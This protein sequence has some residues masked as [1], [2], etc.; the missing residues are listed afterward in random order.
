MEAQGLPDSC[1]TGLQEA[2]ASRKLKRSRQAW[3]GPLTFLSSKWHRSRRAGGWRL[4]PGPCRLVPW[5][6]FQ[7]PILCPGLRDTAPGER[8]ADSSVQPAR[9]SGSPP[10]E[11][12]SRGT[13]AAARLAPGPRPGP[14]GHT[15]GQTRLFLSGSRVQIPCTLQDRGTRRPS[16]SHRK[17]GEFWPAA[18][19]VME[20]DAETLPGSSSALLSHTG[21]FE[22]RR[23]VA[24]GRAR[25]FS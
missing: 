4:F 1:Q 14:A 15:L 10:S 22:T 6:G 25:T 16:G 21:T 24:G 20:E 11:R 5:D 3:V 7:S 9:L 13:A 18:G 12:V 8:P 23:Q 2:G 17:G 19:E